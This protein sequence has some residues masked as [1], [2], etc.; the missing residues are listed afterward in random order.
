MTAQDLLTAAK[1][2]NPWEKTDLGA[3]GVDELKR[4][5]QTLVRQ[6]VSLLSLRKKYGDAIDDTP[7]APYLQSDRAEY[8]KQR[9]EFERIRS[10]LR[11][12]GVETMLFKSVG[13]YP[14]FAYLSSN[15]DVI[16]PGGKA[17]TARKRLASMGY[18]ELVN[19]EEPKKFLFRMFP[20][21]GSSFA[22]HLHEQ[23]GWG[24]P[25]VDNE[26]LW[27]NARP[28]DDDPDI[29]IPGPVE[30]LLAALAHWFYEDKSLSL[31]NLLTSAFAVRHLGCPLET[32]AKSAARRGW[33]E[34]YWAALS[35]FDSAWNRLHGES[36]LDEEQRRSVAEGLGAHRFVKNE[37]LPRVSYGNTDAANVPFM[38]NKV[39]YYR[40][41]IR[42]PARPAGVKA[43]DVASTLLW[44]VR[45]KLHVRS[46]KPL[47]VTVSGC[48]G[49]GKTLQAL[50]LHGVFDT[51]DIRSRVVWARGASSRF[52]G[53]FI[54]PA[55]MLLGRRAAAAENRAPGAAA[56]EDVRFTERRRALENPVARF[57]FSVLYALD[58]SWTYCLKT[59]LLLLLG[60]AVITDRYVYDGVVDYTLLSGGSVERL[61]L[62]LRWLLRAAPRPA[63][64]VVLDVEPT[65][66]LRRKPEEGSTDH[67]E[68]GRRA[69][70]VLSVRE[71]LNIVPADQSPETVQSALALMSLKKFYENY[72][73]LINWLLRSNP[74]Q[75][76]PRGGPG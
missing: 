16:V 40:K 43:L 70:G 61:P 25:F 44:A 8:Q 26:P 36:F 47:L 65:E 35:V 52:M 42:D 15:I 59:R 9:D 62:A 41:V 4:A 17:D 12:D 71:R 76:N 18:V 13:L 66:A 68:E 3:F 29:T 32:P 56:T 60:Y 14:S 2:A 6:K 69:F 63:V 34:G 46:Q 19:V 23:I 50:R 58:L 24:V 45:W 11:V 30:A 38:L 21:D 1:L 28:A 37:L 74:S 49:S 53:V 22:L 7:M 27:R 31:G 10:A 64:P 39:A 73:T 75:L 54:R 67:I 33:A 5:A 55:K 51:C 57:V 72:G 20:G 48:D